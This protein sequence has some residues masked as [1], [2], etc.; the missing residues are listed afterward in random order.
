M[1]IIELILLRCEGD[2]M[3][4]YGQDYLTMLLNWML[5]QMLVVKL[6]SWQQQL[7][8]NT[9]SRPPLHCLKNI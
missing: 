7:W 2:M 3:D 6:Q 4:K 9:A 1:A 8:M 5:L